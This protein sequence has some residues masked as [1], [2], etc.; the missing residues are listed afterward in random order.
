VWVGKMQPLAVSMGS[1]WFFSCATVVD[2]S[3]GLNALE[4]V[5]W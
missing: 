4:S 5:I 1:H 2:R 3:E